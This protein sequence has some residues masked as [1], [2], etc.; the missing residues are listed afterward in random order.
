MAIFRPSFGNKSRYQLILGVLFLVVTL[1]SDVFSQNDDDINGG[2]K[3]N[4]ERSSFE[5]KIP[6]MYIF[7][8][9]GTFS[10]VNGTIEIDKDLYEVKVDLTVDPSTI[11]TGIEKRDEHLKSEDFFDVD[12]FPVISFKAS[13]ISKGATD[14]QYS[15]EGELTIKDVTK[16]IIVPITLE[17]INS[18]GQIVFSGSKNINRREYH[19][20]YTGRGLQDVAEIDFT[21]VADKVE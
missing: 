3:I 10:G 5:F 2:W 12:K 14:N 13:K 15:V 8:V 4:P 9:T 21:I 20:D 17:G 7:P 11:D 18:E 16:E 1:T 6:V 19:I